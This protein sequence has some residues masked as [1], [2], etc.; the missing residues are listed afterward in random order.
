LPPGRKR[1]PRRRARASSR[2]IIPRSRNTGTARTCA[3]GRGARQ[4]PVGRPA[5]VRAGHRR[6]HERVEKL[7]GRTWGLRLHRA[8]TSSRVRR[9]GDRAH[10]RAGPPA[11]LQVRPGRHAHEARHATAKELRAL[12]DLRFE[13][14]ETSDYFKRYVRKGTEKIANMVH[15]YVHMPDRFKEVAPSTFK[16][17][18]SSSTSIPSSRGFEEDQALARAGAQRHAQAPAGR[19]LRRAAAFHQQ[20]LRGAAA[21]RDVESGRRNLQGLHAAEEQ[22]R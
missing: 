18:E 15:A 9:P 12:A 11:G 6:D 14:I 21:R 19:R 1:R 2:W 7:R 16:A 20:G 4:A 8:A 13:G 5:A 10:A 3:D 17:F 22:E